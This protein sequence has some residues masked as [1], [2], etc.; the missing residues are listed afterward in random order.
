MKPKN[1]FYLPIIL[2]ASEQVW[3]DR[4]FVDIDDDMDAFVSTETTS[5]AST[6]SN[7]SQTNKSANKTKQNQLVLF[8]LPSHSSWK[9]QRMKK[10]SP[11]RKRL[12]SKQKKIVGGAASKDLRRISMN[13]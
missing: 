4:N 5:N 10:T 6:A 9:K 12:F 8:H 7:L 11:F 13:N 2:K 1:I 3:N